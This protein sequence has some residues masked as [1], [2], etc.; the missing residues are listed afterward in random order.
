MIRISKLEATPVNINTVLVKWEIA[1]TTEIKSNY[2]YF[3]ER[4]F[5]PQEDFEN[6]SGTS[7][8][9]GLT[10]FLDECTN[11]LSLNRKIFYRLIVKSKTG[12][13]ISTWGPVDFQH[14]PSKVSM[15]LARRNKLILNKFISDGHPV[16]IYISKSVGER[17]PDCWDEV[18]SRVRKSSCE[19]CFGTGFASGFMGPIDGFVSFNPSTEMVQLTDIAEMQPNDVV[20]W[21]S[22]YPILSPRDVIVD[23]KENRRW[24]VVNIS[25]IEHQR[26]IVQ[27]VMR[28]REI[29][30]G[31]IE[32]KLDAY[33]NNPV[34]CCET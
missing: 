22:N 30:P 5:N 27:Q 33:V 26:F 12:S 28:L 29:N 19:T 24:R 31:D 9:I 23:T 4:S 15:E 34:P 1:P 2:E 18:K 17:C 14:K 11:L 25:Q 8:V 3:V 6:I 10:E 32:F 13:Q 16:K 7:G 20:T 21:T